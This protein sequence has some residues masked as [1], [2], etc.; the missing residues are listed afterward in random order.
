MIS[1]AFDSL[2][3]FSN[4]CLYLLKFFSNCNR[5]DY[6]DQVS[7]SYTL[8]T[9]HQ[10]NSDHTAHGISKYRDGHHLGKMVD[11]IQTRLLSRKWFRILRERV[12]IFS[13]NAEAWDLEWS[14]SLATRFPWSF[15][16]GMCV[17]CTFVDNWNHREKQAEVPPFVK[18]WPN[19]ENQ[20]LCC[21][22]TL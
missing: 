9:I 13:M 10:S 8:L 21:S 3:Y 20:L 5:R 14:K 19:H 22:S 18:S 12:K 1:Y 2:T 16:V 17:S 11:P 4:Q 15:G 7:T 6:L